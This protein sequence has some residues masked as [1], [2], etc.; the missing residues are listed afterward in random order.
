MAGVVLAVD[1][2]G[3]AVRMGL[4]RCAEGRVDPLV[5]SRR[6][7]TGWSNFE[8]DLRGFLAQPEVLAN[9]ETA[10]GR[11]AVFA[12]AG[13][14]GG[15]AGPDRGKG[16]VTRWGPEIFRE[17][18]PLLSPLPFHHCILLNDMEAA[19]HAV[20]GTAEESFQP[21]D[22]NACPI[23]RSRFIHLRPGTGLGMGIFSEGL[24][25]PSE[26]GSAPCAFDVDDPDELA[27]ARHF[28]SL[29]GGPLPAYEAALCGDGLRAMS[30][31]LTGRATSPERVTAEWGRSDG[32]KRVVG[33]FLLLLA[34]AAQG[35]ALTL[36]PEAC[37]LSGSIV[38]TLPNGAWESFC[39]AFRHHAAQGLLLKRVRLALVSGPELTLR[40]AA[41]VGARALAGR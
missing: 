15:N 9:M 38:E 27:V 36:Q 20:V 19:N 40:G 21:L 4:F 13:P 33:L 16:S 1:A 30:E 14:T 12:L 18:A 11:A 5:I 24:S 28:R 23:P 39:G 3:T 2:G 26:G 32:S 10:K 41:L 29:S 7:S 35:A 31:A 37:F 34:R 6:A 22:G 17:V 8:G 25:L